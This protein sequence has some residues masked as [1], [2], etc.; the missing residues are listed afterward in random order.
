MSSVISK[1]T[2]VVIVP[3]D[4]HEY[5]IPFCPPE[6][7]NVHYCDYDENSPPSPSPVQTFISIYNFQTQS[8]PAIELPDGMIIQPM[9]RPKVGPSEYK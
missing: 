8:F 1:M 3:D 5:R 7:F 6:D 2:K 9:H 4:I